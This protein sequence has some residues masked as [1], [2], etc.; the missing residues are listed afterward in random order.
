[1]HP[2]HLFEVDELQLLTEAHHSL[3]QY[4]TLTLVAELSKELDRHIEALMR[5]GDE[6][7]DDKKKE[8]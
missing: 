5:K 8:W 7:E 3:T 1:M 4:G 2:R 6:A